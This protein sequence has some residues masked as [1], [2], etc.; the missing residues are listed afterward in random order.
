MS[1]NKETRLRKTKRLAVVSWEC[2]FPFYWLLDGWSQATRRSQEKHD[3]KPS[4]ENWE[5]KCLPV[6]VC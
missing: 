4:L 6:D 3:Q 1:G 2:F 5:G